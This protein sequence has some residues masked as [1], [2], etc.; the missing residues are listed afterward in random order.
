MYSI[1]YL[2][3]I[4]SISSTNLENPDESTPLFRP[5]SL[6]TLTMLTL[7][8][9]LGRDLYEKHSCVFSFLSPPPSRLS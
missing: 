2:I 9:F 4:Y 7:S 3:Y 1:I 6:Q 8:L 5:A